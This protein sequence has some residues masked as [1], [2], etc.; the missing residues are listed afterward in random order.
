[1]QREREKKKNG[2]NLRASVFWFTQ[3][4]SR[5]TPTGGHLKELVQW[6]FSVGGGLP[7]KGTLSRA[8]ERQVSH[9]QLRV[10][11]VH[12]MHWHKLM[13]LREGHPSP[14]LKASHGPFPNRCV[15]KPCNH[16]ALKTHTPTTKGNYI[17]FNVCVYMCILGT[18]HEGF[19]LNLEIGLMA[20]VWW[21]WFDGIEKIY[22]QLEFALEFHLVKFTSRVHLSWFLNWHVITPARWWWHIREIAGSSSLM[23]AY[24]PFWN[25]QCL[26]VTVLVTSLKENPGNHRKPSL[27]C[28]AT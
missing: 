20:L 3:V 10:F 7:S 4:P 2:L 26:G 19:E 8:C 13:D 14:V 17:D 21:H 9:S 24:F 6:Y 11:I 1:M 22:M 15:H 5:S 23:S 27:A 16:A 28:C 25:V 18:C 12:F